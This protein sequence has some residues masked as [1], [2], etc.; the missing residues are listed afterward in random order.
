MSSP[1]HVDNIKKDDLGLGEG[2]TQ[3]LHNTTMIA[4]EKYPS[5]FTESGKRFVLSLHYNGSNRFRTY[6]N[7]KQKK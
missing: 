6:I 7:S 2:S 5:N 3:G 1:E 4:E